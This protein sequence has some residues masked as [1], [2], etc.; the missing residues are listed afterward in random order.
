MRCLS[1]FALIFFLLGGCVGEENGPQQADQSLRVAPLNS[2]VISHTISRVQDLTRFTLRTTRPVSVRVDLLVPAPEDGAQAAGR[3]NDIGGLIRLLDLEYAA[4]D[5]IDGPYRAVVDI[6]G[7]QPPDAAGAFPGSGI[8]NSYSFEPLTGQADDGTDIARGARLIFKLKGPVRVRQAVSLGQAPSAPRGFQIDFLP[9]S[10]TEFLRDI[11]ERKAG[12]GGLPLDLSGPASLPPQKP[13]SDRGVN[14]P[15]P[16]VGSDNRASIPPS[17]PSIWPRTPYSHFARGQP[18]AD[19]LQDLGNAHGIPVIASDKVTGTVNAAFND[20]E[21]GQLFDE[22]VR[23]YGLMWYYDGAAI[24]VY[25]ASEAESRVIR[26]VGIDA[27]G[28]RQ[29]L[30]DLGLWDPRYDWRQTDGGKLIHVTGPPKL[31]E[32]IAS[33]SVEAGEDGDEM[34]IRVVSLNHAWVDDRQFNFRDQSLTIPGVATVLRDLFDGTSPNRATIVASRD[35][36]SGV[37]ALEGLD[38]AFPEADVAAPEVP[39]QALAA[40]GAVRSADGPV[41][42]QADT[43]SNAL[44]IKTT[45]N[46]FPLIRQIISLLDRP[47]RLI[48]IEVSI[49]DLDTFHS[50]ELGIDW[51]LN[52]GDVAV[53]YGEITDANPASGVLSVAVGENAQFSTILTSAADSILARVRALESDGDARIVSRPSVLTMN[54]LQALV[55][56]SRSVYVR[57]SGERT[58]NL[59]PITVG[60]ALKVTPRVQVTSGR[61]SIQ[62]LVDIEDGAILAQT[63]VDNIPT[64]RRTTI[65]TQAVVG[66]GESLLI[67]GLTRDE[68]SETISRIP[69]LG[70]IPIIG[71]GLFS[72]RVTNKR[73][74]ERLF[75]IT[76]RLVAAS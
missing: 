2:Q 4:L 33:L 56:D 51:R 34:V 66:R 41:V 46:L 27:D 63:T 19:L 11:A 18:V 44:I 62:L 12:T 13:P 17:L 32:T 30:V 52:R 39:P 24:H 75:L 26:L 10:H 23:S 73:R 54:N 9:I 71:E 21:P 14:G 6:A 38:G 53:G 47:S 28:L 72:N 5:V 70:S 64:I 45:A 25:S 42:I 48:E 67:G 59:F 61:S 22:L 20:V 31:V 3:A 40:A 58:A 37:T 60:T 16:A 8:I 43:R 36:D 50:E 57:V 74:F 35:A 1:L 55:D 29:R 68:E 7:L 15:D 69:L 76:P 65:H 49:I